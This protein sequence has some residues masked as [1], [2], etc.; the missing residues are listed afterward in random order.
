MVTLGRKR[1]PLTTPSRHFQNHGMGLGLSRKHGVPHTQ[2]AL[3]RVWSC[4]TYDRVDS[5]FCCKVICQLSKLRKFSLDIGRLPF[6][7]DLSFSHFLLLSRDSCERS[8]IGDEARDTGASREYGLSG[9][10]R[11]GGVS[12]CRKERCAL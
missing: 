9:A 7:S 1:D 6:W 11:A 2:A 3:V 8:D 4:L 12:Q 10:L 5:S